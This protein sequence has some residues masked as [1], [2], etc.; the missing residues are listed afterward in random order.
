MDIIGGCRAVQFRKIS[1]YNDCVSVKA[2][3]SNCI[4]FTLQGFVVCFGAFFLKPLSC[5]FVFILLNLLAMQAFS[6]GFPEG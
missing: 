6:L 1:D 2:V 5:S 3:N 4:L